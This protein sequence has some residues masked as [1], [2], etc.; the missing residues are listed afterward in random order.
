MATHIFTKEQQKLK[1][2]QKEL[3]NNYKEQTK[4][5]VLSKN[6]NQ[7]I[8][9]NIW[10][11]LYMLQNYNITMD[12]FKG[13]NLRWQSII[14]Y[15]TYIR[16]I[17]KGHKY[18]D[19]FPKTLLNYIQGLMDS[20]TEPYDLPNNKVKNISVNELIKSG[21][22]S[23]YQI[24][25]IYKPVGVDDSPVDTSSA[26]TQSFSER[27]NNN[28]F[29]RDSYTNIVKEDIINHVSTNPIVV[30]AKFD[31]NNP[32]NFDFKCNKKMTN[33]KDIFNFNLK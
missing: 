26:W 17:Y 4:Q 18:K 11:K 24:D 7:Q 13:A 19:P 9:E 25:Y 3:I 15:L 23:K 29:E 31:K 30:N 22:L 28:T 8:L 14:T 27:Q 12:M 32:F 10:Y 16:A 33:L 2:L 21:I 1:Q 6:E 5:K 20:G